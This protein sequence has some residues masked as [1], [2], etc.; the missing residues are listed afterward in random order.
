MENAPWFVLRTKAR[1]E[2]QV[3]AVLAQRNVE[4]FLPLLKR[5]KPT[6]AGYKFTPLFSCY[7]FVRFQIP[8]DEYVRSRSAPGVVGLVTFDDEPAAVSDQ[9]IQSIRDRL[10][11]ENR[12]RR[13]S[14][15]EVGQRVVIT[16]GPFKDIEAIF[17]GRLTAAGRAQVLIDL[18]GKQWRVHVP[19][20]SLSKAD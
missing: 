14:P 3:G 7:L 13:P 12:V 15:F 20:G 16:E 2:E 6:R 8:S 11:L 19:V 17:D 10:E 1:H 18:L 5:S 9:I 4:Y